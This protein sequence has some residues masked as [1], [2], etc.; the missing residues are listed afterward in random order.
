MESSYIVYCISSVGVFLLYI[1][2]VV[3]PGAET[4]LSVAAAH[5]LVLLLKP[6]LHRMQCK[7]GIRYLLQARWLLLVQR[8]VKK[9]K[10]EQFN[11]RAEARAPV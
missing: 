5:C 3:S 10:K 2:S 7:Q 6:L 9:V 1:F 11:T 4:V 8:L